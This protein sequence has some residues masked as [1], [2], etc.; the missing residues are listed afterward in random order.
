[1]CSCF[2]KEK[3]HNPLH[4]GGRAL[5]YDDVL[6]LPR[7]AD[8]MPSDASIQTMLT[9]AILLNIP[10]VSAAMDTVTEFSMAIALALE[11]GIGFIHQN[12]GAKEQATQVGKVKRFQSGKIMNPFYLGERATA[13]DALSM[14]HEAKVG[15]ILI[16]D[17]R[18]KLLGIVT[19]RDLHSLQDTNLPVLEV[20][21]A[22]L[23]TAPPT[24]SLEEAE[25]LL[26]RHKVEKLPLVDDDNV[27][28][29][30]VTYKDILERRDRPYAC[31]DTEGRLRVGAAIGV[32]EDMMMR[33]EQLV[34][35]HVDVIA[36]DTAHGHSKRV[37]SAI[38]IIKQ[39]YPTLPLIAGNV[40][41]GE[42]AL[43]L[44]EAGADGIKVGIGPGS[45]CT[46]RVVA[47][48]G[49]PQFSAVCDVAQ[50]LRGKQVSIISDGGIRFSGDIVKSV[51][52][53]ADCVMIGSLLAGTEES[54]GDVVLLQGKKYKMYRGMGSLESMKKGGERRY[55]KEGETG[56]SV[57]EG[58]VGR[59]PYRGAVSE[60]IHQ[61]KGGVKA[62]MGYTGSPDVPAL[63]R[64][65]F[66]EI[67]P[68][69]MKE[70]HPHDISIV[71]DAP[72]Y[73]RD[74]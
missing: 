58:V 37:L 62:G 68:S 55:F 20:M 50:A 64:A 29:G 19:H 65:S 39:S 1:M 33:V 51:A 10:I 14:M 12:M 36:I 44:H 71:Q 15:G 27:L 56:K 70:S 73:S 22:H 7:Y 61:L 59:V 66:I 43:A 8:F 42:A 67:T 60:V 63:K 25:E 21:T 72:N 30:L 5:A 6:L 35:N 74:L 18:H 47:G 24:V 40:A 3:I 54:P 32:G 28:K 16:V 23:H 48:V 41:L 13:A 69:G 26:R 49:V 53:G 57:P 4:D 17:S 46:T 38:K 45:I 34:Q 11:G 9:P 31:K 2:M 52:A